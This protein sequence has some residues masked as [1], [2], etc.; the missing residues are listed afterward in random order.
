[1]SAP[2]DSASKKTKE[3]S[4]VHVRRGRGEGPNVK[5]VVNGSG[6]THIVLPQYFCP[7]H[8]GCNLLC[9]Q[10]SIILYAQMT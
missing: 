10:N 1:M 6:G 4:S 3:V 7:R 2:C 5:E 9:L 8:M